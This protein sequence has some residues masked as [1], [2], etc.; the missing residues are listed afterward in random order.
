MEN[1]KG[2]AAIV[3]LGTY[4]FSQDSGI[5]ELDMACRAVKA[6]LDDAALTPDCVDGFVEYSEEDFDEILITRSMGIGN[7][8]FHGDVRWD[9]AS[10][11]SMVQRGA[12][13][14]TAGMADTV[15]I[16][17]SV[18]DA[19]L[20]RQKKVFGERR[21]W[22][23]LEETYYNPYGLLTDAGRMGLNIRRYIHAYGIAP[24]AFG[25]I[26]MVARE[27]GARNPNSLFFNQPLA[28]EDYLQSPMTVD[29][30]R[31][32]D[33]APP[34]DGAMALIVTSA[35]RARRICDHPVY[36]LS[37]AQSMVRGAQFKTSYALPVIYDQPAL[38]NVGRRL[39]EGAGLTTADI[40]VVQIEDELAPLVPM[41]LEELGFC[42]RG[43]GPAFIEDGKRIRPDGELPL[44]TSGGAIGEGH[45]HGFNHVA[46]AV[47]Q[48]RGT[49][50]SPVD[51]AKLA[52]VV[53]GAFGPASGLI[54]GR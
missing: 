19:S 15:V 37:A 41:A 20:R 42:R 49:S 33:L 26:S 6:A 7:L 53:S 40:D 31:R 27:N 1:F 16:V 24:E 30:L 5:T 17:R 28:Y 54:L 29:P 38:R 32:L 3:G 2:K 8:T 48:L 18:N 39:F 46:E 47:R 13:A 23:A 43:E 14:V 34:V 4:A 35:E 22:T 11:C 45:L 10:A 44:N 25:W 21:T 12:M 50:P 51:N 52:L 9:G 36:I